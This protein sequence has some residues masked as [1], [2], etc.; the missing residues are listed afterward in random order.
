MPDSF[1][2]LPPDSTGKKLDAVDYT[3]GGNTVHRQRVLAVYPRGDQIPGR[4]PITR[5]YFWS[6]TS[7][8]TTVYSPPTGQKLY[9]TTLS[10]TA[11]NVSATAAGGFYLKDGGTNGL[12]LM[13]CSVPSTPAGAVPAII[14]K[15]LTFVEPLPFGTALH[16]ES[17]GTADYRVALFF[18]GYEE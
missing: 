14:T 11:Y 8:N 4:T 17:N 2:Q 1:I 10:I 15:E 6:T 18:H 7:F 9:V 16:M 3:V 5:K 13:Q 12:V